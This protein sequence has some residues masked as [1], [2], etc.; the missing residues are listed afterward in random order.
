MYLNNNK[1]WNP[2]DPGGPAGPASNILY[3][4]IVKKETRVMLDNMNH[5]FKYL[6]RWSRYLFELGK[7]TFSTNTIL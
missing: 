2:G 5:S 7:G 4:K 6:S 3:K 1:P